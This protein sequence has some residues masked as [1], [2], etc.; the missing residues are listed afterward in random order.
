MPV[1]PPV[2]RACL[3]SLLAADEPPAPGPALHEVLAADAARDDGVAGWAA[4]L[5]VV[6]VMVGG[7]TRLAVH[8]EQAPARP[9]AVTTPA[10]P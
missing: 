4:W 10:S 1:V 2:P 3:P 8:D 9:H 6:A 5:L 7:A